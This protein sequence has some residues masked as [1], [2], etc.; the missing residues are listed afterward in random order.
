MPQGEDTLTGRNVLG[1][2]LTILRDLN[3]REANTVR[4]AGRLLAMADTTRL[5]VGGSTAVP[6]PQPHPVLS[7]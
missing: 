4:A 3:A 1:Q 7:A 6:A 2:I 5:I